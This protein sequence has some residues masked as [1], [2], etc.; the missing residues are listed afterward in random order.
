MKIDFLPTLPDRPAAGDGGGGGRNDA[1]R[2]QAGE[3]FAAAVRGVKDKR[4]DAQA[5]AGARAPARGANEAGAA[6]ADGRP[7]AME[8]DGGE[9]AADPKAD[10]S[11]ESDPL[12]A[13]LDLFGLD[14]LR[15]AAPAD[16]AG[17]P[18]G[19]APPERGA[20][21]AAPVAGD[22]EADFAADGSARHPLRLDVLRMETHFEPRRDVVSGAQ[23]QSGEPDAAAEAAE[24]S[25]AAPS[26]GTAPPADA[27]PLPAASARA[28]AAPAAPLAA[29]ANETARRPADRAPSA[30]ETREA[31]S[32]VPLRFE[33]AVARLGSAAPTGRDPGAGNGEGGREAQSRAAPAG[34]ERR[35]AAAARAPF[36]AAL[37][38]TEAA[39]RADAASNAATGST[40]AAQV[41]Q[42]IGE[43]F[44]GDAALAAPAGNEAP[45]PGAAFAPDADGHLRLRAG[46][47]ALRTLTLQLQPEHL[48]TLEVSLRLRDGQLA[49]EI[50]ASRPETAAA[51]AGDEAALR[52]LLE[53]AGFSLDDGAIAITVRDASAAPAARAGDAP[54]NGSGGGASSGGGSAGADSGPS[55]RGGEA[56]RDPSGEGRRA[57]PREDAPR[58]RS[59]GSTYL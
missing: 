49:L 32:P 47:A 45:R 58:A 31:A 12:R 42:R 54:A 33:E 8:T 43:A 22:A 40:L 7:V 51:L 4:G 3:G 35:E 9:A 59:G 55:D 27:D 56:R 13:V 53:K 29:L 24:P 15:R 46:G 48:G 57:P 37:S 38:R 21:D 19:E 2:A 6:E 30:A 16:A 39:A 20:P 28:P 36:A 18:A 41:A 25:A 44:G 50:G 1:A 10:R 34:A 11:T 52:Q 23:A 17:E 5:D 26:A 14:P